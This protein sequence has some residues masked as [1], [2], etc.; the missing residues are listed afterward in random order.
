ML[1][2]PINVRGWPHVSFYPAEVRPTLLGDLGSALKAIVSQRL[3][4]TVHNTRMP[5][6]EVMLNSRLT[7]ELIEQGDFSGVKEAMNNSLAEGSQTFEHDIA[8]LITEGV[9][10]RKEGIAHADSPTNLVWRLQNDFAKK[11]APQLQ[12]EQQTDEASFTE[13]TLDVIQPG[14]DASA[15]GRP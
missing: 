2:I 11:S 1:E 9:V 14:A 6:V 4:R 10:D 3:L 13:I 7:A 8:R 5:A 15:M 12:D